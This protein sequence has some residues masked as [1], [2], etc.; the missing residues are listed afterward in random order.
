MSVSDLSKNLMYYFWYNNIKAQYGDKAILLYTDTDS[1]KLQVE[2]EMP[3]K[4]RMNMQ[5][6]MISVSFQITAHII[7]MKAREL[8]L[9][10][11]M[12]VK[13]ISLLTVLACEQRCTLS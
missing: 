3:I 11:K 2:I 5:K 9:S 8:L 4:T 12:N 13:V 6:I 7:I 10:S 1:L